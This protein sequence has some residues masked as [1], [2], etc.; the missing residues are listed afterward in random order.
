[1]T[2]YS[3][4]HTK[5]LQDSIE[6]FEQLKRKLLHTKWEWPRLDDP[7][8]PPDGR[9]LA[10]SWSEETEVIED[11]VTLISG[12]PGLPCIA[13]ASQMELAKTCRAAPGVR[14]HEEPQETGRMPAASEPKKTCPVLVR[15]CV[16]VSAV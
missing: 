13:G 9:G 4:I 3:K 7:M 12:F 1:M 15:V 2:G 10:A 5:P 14:R 11:I 16:C 6:N 8:Q